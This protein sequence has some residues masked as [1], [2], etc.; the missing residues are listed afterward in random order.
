[1]RSDSRLPDLDVLPSVLEISEVSDLFRQIMAAVEKHPDIPPIAVVECLIDAIS[2][3]GYRE[4]RIDPA[5]CEPILEWIRQQWPS[6]DEEFAD[7][8]IAVLANLTC[9]GVDEYLM[10]LKNTETREAVL[11]EVEFAIEERRRYA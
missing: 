1:M 11:V 10:E 3:Q 6:G 7:T 4:E 5:V 8:A 2:A 9:D